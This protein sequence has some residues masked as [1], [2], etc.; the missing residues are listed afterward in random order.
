MF[1]LEWSVDRVSP[2][3]PRV[4]GDVPSVYPGR[5]WLWWF[6]PRTRGCSSP[7]ALGLLEPQVF[8]AYAGM[9]RRA[10]PENRHRDRFPRVRGDVPPNAMNG[11]M[12]MTFSPRTRGCSGIVEVL[13]L[14]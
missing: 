8:P 3:F 4:R 13:W 2:C 14:T 12:A 1:R 5:C 7:I 11:F 9:F 10:V 6:S